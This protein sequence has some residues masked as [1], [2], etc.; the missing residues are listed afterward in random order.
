MTDDALDAEIILYQSEGSNGPV[1]VR[2]Q[3]ETM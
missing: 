2:Y 1:E 3:D